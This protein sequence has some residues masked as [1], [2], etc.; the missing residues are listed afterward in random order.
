M[1]V[2]WFRGG[3]QGAPILPRW[4][5]DC[6]VFGDVV[7]HLVDPEPML[8][9]LK[10]CLAPG[11]QMLFSV[12]N[13]QH[14]S[15]IEML[16]NGQWTYSPGLVSFSHLRFYTRSSFRALLK[17]VGLSRK[18]VDAI[19]VGHMPETIRDVAEAVGNEALVEDATMYQMIFRSHDKEPVPRIS[20]VIPAH[21]LWAQTRSCLE[22]IAAHT[23][24][25]HEVIVIDNASTDETW[26][27]LTK[28]SA[29]AAN[30][31]IRRNRENLPY[32][33]A[34]N[35]GIEGAL[36]EYVVVMNNDI[37]VTDGWLGKMLSAMQRT[38]AGIVGPVSNYVAGEQKR[39]DFVYR[40]NAQLADYARRV[41]YGELS[42]TIE[43]QAV[44]GFCMLIERSVFDT[45][46]LFDQQFVNGYEETDFCLRAG[47]AGKKAVI[48]CDTFIYHVGSQTFI[49]TNTDYWAN[50]EENHQKFIAKWPGRLPEGIGSKES[51][52][53]F[54]RP[55]PKP[56]PILSFAGAE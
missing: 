20:I 15:V 40:D 45:I 44:V 30:L 53:W 14:W 36:G 5:Y 28:L 2:G 52:G 38:G 4:Y 46:G 54:F 39:N 25:D 10:R 3:A 6:I 23:P 24:Q 8:E 41:Y 56:L 31:Q 18:L 43:T 7:E 35:Q 19:R 55:A 13:V 9:A 21:N 29:D 17:R 1:C 34:C 12:P 11:G 42:K 33:A 16:L 51:S 22:S 49:E 50:I 27:E 26:D 47:E 32:A 37:V 48:A